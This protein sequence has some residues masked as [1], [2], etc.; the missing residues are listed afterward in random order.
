M[1]LFTYSHNNGEA[2][3]PP[4]TQKRLYR[5]LREVKGTYKLKSA[6]KLR[7][8]ILDKLKEIGWTTEVPIALKP[9]VTI[10]SKNGDVGLCMQFGNMARFYA[11]LLKMQCFF[12]NGR[13]TSGIYIIPT[14]SAAKAMASNMVHYERVTKELEL[15]KNIIDMPLLVIGVGGDLD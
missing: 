8:T 3:V 12:E 2:L 5:V 7:R 1:N 15:Y 14:K 11:D 13:I 4:T 9:R 6:P 10:T